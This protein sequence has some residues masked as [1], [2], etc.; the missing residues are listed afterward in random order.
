MTEEHIKKAA[1]NA[2]ELLERWSGDTVVPFSDFRQVHQRAVDLNRRILSGELVV[3]H[4][5]AHEELLANQK[6]RRK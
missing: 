5:S 6:R 3:L 2:C 1:L 4:Q